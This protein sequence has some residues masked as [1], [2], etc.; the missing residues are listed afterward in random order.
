MTRFENRQSAGR[1]LGARLREL[2]HG[3]DSVVI[4]LPRGGVPVAY[5]VASI[6]GAPLD[7]LIVR[8]L[9]A[10]GN[11]EF[12]LGAVD[13]DGEIWSDPR[14]LA[15]ADLGRDEW[16][17]IQREALEET[18]RR[19]RYYRGA[20][21]PI[22][23]E[24]KSVIVVDDGLATGVSAEVA[25]RHLRRKGAA[26]ITL[27]VP[28]CAAVSERRIRAEGVC[29]DIVALISEEDF[30]AVS[31]WYEDFSQTTDLEVMDLLG[32]VS[33]G[34]PGLV[35]N[36][37]VPDGCRGIV[38]FAHG[39]GS[40]RLSP[41][42]QDVARRLNEAGFATLLFDLLLEREAANRSLVF[43]VKLL[44]SRLAMATEWARARKETA[45]LPIGYFGASTGAAAAIW[46]ASKP[47]LAIGCVVSRGGR[48][49]LAEGRLEHVECPVLL[50]VGGADHPVIRLNREAARRLSQGRMEIVP[51]A[52]HLFEEPGALER[53]SDLAVDWFS[54][55]LSRV[56]PLGR[57]A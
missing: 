56:D 4:A 25:M 3:P 11:P 28:A 38:I 26:R 47:E 5:E 43:D 21:A 35:G 53:V 8:K 15:S 24:G 46:A 22:G 44:S 18:R 23:V 52:G 48:P 2:G 34:A 13:E 6:L 16:R 57:A 50:I 9:G 39:S 1:L 51:G 27:A 20:R 29:D 10:P 36:W 7:V 30:H 54:I 37:N 19:V 32:R 41:R 17:E 42:N 49:D 14:V 12:G 33:I 45:G 31:R 55:H 40:S